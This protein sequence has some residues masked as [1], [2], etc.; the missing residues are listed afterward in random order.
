MYREVLVKNSSTSCYTQK[1]ELRNCAV[2]LRY[3]RQR[4]MKESRTANLVNMY[5][6]IM[7]NNVWSGC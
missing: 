5:A 1:H 3:K 4:K 6:G 7:Y 2:R